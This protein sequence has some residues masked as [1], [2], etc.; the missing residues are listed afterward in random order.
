MRCSSWPTRCCAPTA[1]FARWSVCPWR[2]STG[3]GRARSPPGINQGRVDLARLRNLVAA[4]WL[5]RTAD[6]RIVLAVDVS[7]WLRPDANTS[8]ERSFCHT[9]GR[10]K[11]QHLM[12]PSWPYSIVAALETGRTSWTALLD[13]VRLQPGADVVAVTAVQIREVVA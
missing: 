13:A 11:D 4:Q 5:R 1:R 2:R 6:D 8:P 10:G 12:M 9:Y 7:P 3:G